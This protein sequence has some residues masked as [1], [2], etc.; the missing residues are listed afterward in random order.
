LTAPVTAI[1]PVFVTVNVAVLSV[2]A[3]ISLL[4]IAMIFW[5]VGTSTARLAG[6]VEV[7]VGAVASLVAPVLKVHTYAWPSGT[8]ARSEAPD[9][10]LPVYV[11]LGA[12]FASGL[13]IEVLLTVVIVPFTRVPSGRCKTRDAAIDG[14]DIAWLKVTESG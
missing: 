13:K 4:K 9:L 12:R 8:P 7:T 3:D 11:V 1:P 14:A 10:T 5:L 2:P 6:L